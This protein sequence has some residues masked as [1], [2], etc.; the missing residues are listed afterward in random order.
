MKIVQLACFRSNIG[1]NANI[2][3]TRR[4]L[5]AN[6]GEEPAYSP[7][8]LL[9]YSW[10]LDHYS[11]ARIDFV[12]EHDLLVIGGGGFFEIL[13]EKGAESWT[14]TRINIPELLFD[15]IKIPVVFHGVGVDAWRP[16]AQRNIERFGRFLDRILHSDQFLVST[17]N[18]GSHSTLERLYGE[19]MA[20]SVEV[21]PDGGFFV[22][23]GRH[24]HPE[25]S[26]HRHLLINLAGDMLDVRFPTDRR[27]R[28]CDGQPIAQVPPDY[29]LYTSTR[30]ATLDTFLDR[31]AGVLKRRLAQDPD[32]SLVIVPHIYRD[33]AIGARLIDIIGFP[34]SRRRISMAPYLNGQEGSDYIFDLYRS[35]D[36]VLGM[37]FHANV[38]PIGL[39]APTLGLACYPQIDG[40]YDEIGQPDRRI[41][42]NEDDF[43][44]RLETAIERSF[45]EGDA[46]RRRYAGLNFE[47]ANRIDRFHARIRER[48]AR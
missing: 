7:W 40:L 31:L 34:F 37:R 19:A 3:G 11:Q 39:G 9:D 41:A 32:L 44:T 22:V 1:D 2:D 30:N 18:D 16:A 14:G 25:A 42:V 29:E 45:A 27:Q 46:V 35:A 38:C 21:I 43:E 23:P 24:L 26:G 13:G 15:R 20:R 10:G 17:R 6:L 47:L 36:L 8:E 28:E 4:R 48:I 33:I 5:A 12:N